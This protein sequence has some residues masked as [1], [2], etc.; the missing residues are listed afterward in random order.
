INLIPFVAII[1]DVQQIGTAYGGDAG[2]MLRL[3]LRNVGGNILLLMPLG[4]LSP[5]MWNKFKQYKNV[6]LLGFSI[7]IGIECIQFIELI[8]GGFGR[9]VDIDDVICNVVGVM[10]GY[11]IYKFMFKIADQ[12]QITIL[13]NLNFKST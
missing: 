11:I 4:I 12:F 2:F 9:A 5:I 13:Q 3:I 8:A 7:S 6:V 1:K 10:L